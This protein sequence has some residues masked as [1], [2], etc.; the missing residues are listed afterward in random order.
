MAKVAKIKISEEKL[1]ELREELRLLI[2]E[3]LPRNR[4]EIK[5]AREQGDLSENADYHA[6]REQNAKFEARKKE[7]ENILNNYELINE[8][9]VGSNIGIGSSVT[10]LNIAKNQETTIRL[11]GSIEADPFAEIPK[12]SIDSPLGR[13]LLSSRKPQDS[14]DEVFVDVKTETGKIYKIQILLSK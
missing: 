12:I 7:V 1:L 14:T 3:V 9:S 6:A 5:E 11:V 13:A 4:E 2:D 8:A 10:Y